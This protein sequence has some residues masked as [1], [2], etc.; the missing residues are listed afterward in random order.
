MAP[1]TILARLPPSLRVLPI[2]TES[3]E[4]HTSDNPVYL[5]KFAKA[6]IFLSKVRAAIKL[7]KLCRA[8]KLLKNFFQRFFFIT[9]Q[10]RKK[11]R[12]KIKVST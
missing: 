4:R 11:S 5:T 6:K 8:R 3:E 2:K 10:M 12:T 1:I 9:E 7:T